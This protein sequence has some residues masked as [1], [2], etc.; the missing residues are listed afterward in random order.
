MSTKIPSEIRSIKLDDASFKDTGT[1]IENL[2]FVNFFF[3][4]N[5]SGKSTIANVIRSGK[6]ITYAPGKSSND[7]L[8]LVYNENF[9]EN[10]FHS[11]KKM[12]GVFTINEVNKSVQEQIDTLIA[13]ETEIKNS[14]NDAVETLEQKK[15]SLNAVEKGFWKECWDKSFQLRSWF[16]KTLEG[17][18]NSKKV[19][20]SSILPR[21]P[22]NQDLDELRRLYDSAFS[23]STSYYKLFSFIKDTSV[24]DK[25]SGHEIL[26][27][28][29]VNS[30]D[31][32]FAQFIRRIQSTEWVRQGHE[33]FSH[34]SNGQCPYCAQPLPDKFETLF[35]S[36]FDAQYEE[37]LKKLK[38]FQ[39]SYRKSANDLFVPLKVPDPLY[40]K[41]NAK[42]YLDK[43]DELKTTIRLNLE[44]IA[45][46]IENPATP[47]TLK[48]TAPILEEL[49][50]M[51]IAFNNLITEN[52]IIV[53]DI[54][55]KRL[56]CTDK[57]FSY[58][59]F[60]LKDVICNYKRVKANINSEIQD[61]ETKIN[62]YNSQQTNI[63]NEIK[64]LNSQ[65]VETES[66]KEKIN[67]MLRDTGMHGFQ[68]EPHESEPHV[69]K[70]VRPDGSI[71]D[72][73]S[74]GE[75]NFLAFLYFYYL[76]QGGES[77][78]ESPREKIVVIDDPVSSMDSNSLF[79]VSTL[80]KSMIEICRNNADNENATLS[81]KY[82]KQLFILTHNAFFHQEITHSYVPRYEY[83]SFFL[84]RKPNGRSNV[85]FCDT[86]NPKE[87]SERINVNPVKN[88]YAA[89]WEEYNEIQSA[90]PLM[91]VIRKILEY[92]FLQLCGYE[93]STLRKVILLDNKELFYDDDG[94]FNEEKYLLASSMLSYI[95]ADTKG[96]NE[97]MYHVDDCMDTEECRTMFE[98]IF[99]LMQQE[100]HFLKMCMPYKKK[101]K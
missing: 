46:K 7:Y 49:D 100:Q 41:I 88:S 77:A 71:A 15:S 21:T 32:D 31:T 65:T 90:V 51:I 62:D 58:I 82:I 85:K 16:D 56:E 33:L 67:L 39:E 45:N 4:N 8:P 44:I 73:L 37:N 61:L 94:N 26:G 13:E 53:S 95:S 43:L 86:L 92:Y 25:Q 101:A 38:I 22:V 34:V 35:T 75:K 70:V 83:V 19:F 81:G 97:G 74:E 64:K 27:L 52:N 9:I 30:S 54:P 69:Y 78:D 24:L 99:R 11:Y 3:G 20:A 55:K 42:F 5:G 18:R 66:A 17:T 76:V 60:E 12:P 89:L 47:V 28:S 10:N 40:S 36:S 23:S 91:N 63:R 50:G 80:V 98:M 59:A 68:L 14:I 84:V 79:I 72:N 57:V 93:G 2:T 29:I 6:G 87:P 48:E 96:I 1:K